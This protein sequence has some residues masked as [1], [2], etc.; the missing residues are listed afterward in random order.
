MADRTERGVLCLKYVPTED[1]VADM[2]T[3]RLGFSQV[4][5]LCAEIGLALL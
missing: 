1:N 3:K 5:H 2:L 4:Q